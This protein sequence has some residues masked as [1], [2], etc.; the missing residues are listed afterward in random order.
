MDAIFRGELLGTAVLILLGNG[1][2]AATLLR[3]SKAEGA[4]WLAISAGWAFAVLIGVLCAQAAGS[5]QALLNPAVSLFVAARSGEWDLLWRFVPAQF[6]GAAI[7]ATL[8]WLFYLPLYATGEDAELKRATFCTSPASDCQ[9]ASWVA[10][11]LATCVLGVAIAAIA[12][13]G[14][15]PQG[16]P[17]G[18]GPILVGFLVWSIGLSLGG[19][20]GY[21]INPARDLAPRLMHALLPIPG[22]GSSDW[23]YALTPVLAPLVG[24]LLAAGLVR[25]FA[26]G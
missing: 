4:G 7:G 16:L 21:A 5:P 1:V 6:L 12:S 9:C 10:E 20:T 17:A 22:K 23:G 14:V 26:I 3:G 13:P 8:V 19:M 25:L 11:A 24:A 18:V 2:V 15:A